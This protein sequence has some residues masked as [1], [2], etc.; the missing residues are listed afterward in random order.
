MI[1]HKSPLGSITS[2]QDPEVKIKFQQPRSEHIFTKANASRNVLLHIMTLD[3]INLGPLSPVRC[4][5]ILFISLSNSTTSHIKKMTLGA[6]RKT[7][8]FIN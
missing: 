2:I 1:W 5:C 4:S 3:Y 8:V 6:I 7:I